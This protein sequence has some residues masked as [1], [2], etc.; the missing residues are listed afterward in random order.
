MGER[1]FCKPEA[2]SSS[3]TRSTIWGVAESV[4]Q[5]AVNQKIAR[6]SRASPATYA[7]FV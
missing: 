2:V 5:L 6:S 7:T 4:Q 1:W 3:L